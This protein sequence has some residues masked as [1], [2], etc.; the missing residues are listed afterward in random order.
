ME[1]ELSRTA[2]N[3]TDINADITRQQRILA[4]EDPRIVEAE[5]RIA[6]IYRQAR[7][8]DIQIKEE[9]NDRELTRAR[10]VA[11]FQKNAADQINKANVA[12]AKSV[13]KIHREYARDVSKA[14]D[15]S[16]G[17]AAKRMAT[18]TQLLQV[19]TTLNLT[20]MYR[21]QAGFSP[22]PAE[23]DRTPEYNQ[24]LQRRD[25]LEKQLQSRRPS[26]DATADRFVAAYA[27]QPQFE[28]IATTSLQGLLTRTSGA[29][30]PVPLPVSG[31][32][33]AQGASNALQAGQQEQNRRD[34]VLKITTEQ[35]NQLRVL[36]DQRVR[37]EDQNKLYQLQQKYIR[38]GVRPALVDTYAQADLE[39]ARLK[40]T[41]AELTPIID[42]QVRKIKELAS[43]YEDA[44]QAAR[45]AQDNRVGKGLRE[46]AM[47]YVQS[48]GTLREAT[49]QLAQTGIKGVEDALFSLV[50]TGTAN[51]REF[52]ASILK[53]T[54]R[55]I[56]QQMILRQV[57][58][59][60]SPISS[61]STAANF[62][63][64]GAAFIPQGGFKLNALGAAYAANGI[65]PFARGGAFSHGITAYAM[66]GV[67]KQPTMFAFANGGAG[68][69][70]LMGEAGPEAIMPLRRL[71]SGRLGVESAGGGGMNVV[72]NVDASG[73]QV[74]GNSAD[75]SQLGKVL[76]AA[77]QQELIKQQRPGGL[78]A[79]TR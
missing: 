50:T 77:V 4:G 31:Y 23:K 52:A 76:S 19:L 48:M 22:V 25:R 66:G 72:V 70:G 58:Q 9:F 42:E 5:Q 26:P 78:L 16:S 6:N 32:T 45:F 3:T 73:S 68:R 65:Q 59:I 14:L 24:L 46:G 37:L 30:G 2:R 15:E 43:A 69:L 49:S 54:A 47:Q 12:Y 51:F 57:M 7:E 27:A 38:D 11:D 13:G 10:T 67:V 71:P 41:N 40:V 39:A 75:A 79:P 53:D 56:I 17:K 61:S 20:G 33:G 55:M 21:Y 74:Q 1:R 64:P 63:M 44:Q 60:F 35:E 62:E 18:A 28:D 8:R 34:T 36:I 29:S